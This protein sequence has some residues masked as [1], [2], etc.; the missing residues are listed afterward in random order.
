MKE[1]IS[2]IGTRGYVIVGA[3]RVDVIVEDVK[4]VYGTDKL[5][6]RQVSV[7]STAVKDET[8]Q[9]INKDSFHSTN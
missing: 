2:L 5:Y 3:W 8:A 1:L 7:N 9:W 4:N 6:V